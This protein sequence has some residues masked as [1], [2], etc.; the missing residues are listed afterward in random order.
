M[1]MLRD[2]YNGKVPDDFNELLKLPGVGRKSANQLWERFEQPRLAEEVSRGKASPRT[3]AAYERDWATSVGPRWAAVPCTDVRPYD[4][5]EWLLG[6]TRSAG[7]I[8]KSLLKT[9]LDNA[10]MLDVLPA[11]PAARSYRLGRDTAR[12]K[13][14]FTEHQLSE[15]WRAVEGSPAEVPFLLSAHAGLRVGEACG[16]RVADVEFRPDVAVLRVRVQLTPKGDVTERLKTKGSYR[17][18]GL[19]QPWA[20]RLEEIAASLP[21]GAVYLN[22]TGL[23]TPV[24]RRTVQGWWKRLTAG[25]GVPYQ[26]LQALRPS[27]Q[28]NL[29]WSGVPIEM[30][31]KILGHSS[32]AMTIETYDRPGEDALVKVVVDAQ[33]RS[34]LGQIGTN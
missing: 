11:N 12:E 17:T 23:G 30:T 8:S 2:E 16:M 32:T 31:S 7:N 26:P 28:T 13:F 34:Q 3:L 9:T 18:V 24:N 22:D 33:K 20:G 21:A 14:A 1:K 10:V 27:F 5:Q 15:L 6:K 4:I 25:T 19:P 29:H